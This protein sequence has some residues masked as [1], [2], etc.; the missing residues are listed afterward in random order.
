M[1][2]SERLDAGWA[3]HAEA[4]EGVFEEV[5]GLV[6]D[7]PQEHLAAVANLLFHV[8]GEHLGRFVHVQGLL[9]GML[10]CAD[11]PASAPLRRLL[12]ACALCEGAPAGAEAHLALVPGD[13][14]V[15]KGIV[16]GLAASAL[17]AGGR[18]DEAAAL[19]EATVE[20]A[21]TTDALHR[22]VAIT[23]NNLAAALEEKRGRSAAEDTLMLRAAEAARVYWEKAGTWVNVERA[24]YRLAMTHLA[25]GHADRAIAH[26][27]R[28][29]AIVDA[30]GPNPG[31]AFFGWE[32]LCR[33]RLL[34]GETAGA[35]A[36]RDA[37]ADCVPR[38]EDEGFRRFCVDALAALDA[39]LRA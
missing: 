1:N 6:A 24:E 30:N 12:A 17:A 4:P 37:A 19:F 39:R 8:G 18:T 2:I 14:A 32:V 7:A 35:T 16:C 26:A 28:A 38:V 36:A 29:L 5:C 31:E 20:L 3:R 9:E 34:A 11:A 13:P 22:S 15:A 33:A 27:E 23:G 25:R 21:E 10:A